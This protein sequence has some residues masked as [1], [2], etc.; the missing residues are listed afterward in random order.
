M[1]LIHC[2]SPVHTGAH[3][4]TN[5]KNVIADSRE[6]NNKPFI[7]AWIAHTSLLN[8]P[9]GTTRLTDTCKRRGNKNAT[10]GQMAHVNVLLQ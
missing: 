6:H 10:L 1:P 4:Q 9:V 2:F 8:L 5:S 3:M 7:I